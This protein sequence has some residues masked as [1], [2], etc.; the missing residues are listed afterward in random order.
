MSIKSLVRDSIS[1][2]KFFIYLF[3]ASLILFSL[4]Y[5]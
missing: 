1:L 3:F 2:L 4:A 5:L